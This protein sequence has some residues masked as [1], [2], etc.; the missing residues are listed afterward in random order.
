ML[1]TAVGASIPV[2]PFIFSSGVQALVISFVISTLA[3]F[4]VGAS[5]VIVTG[6]SWLKSGAEMTLI[7]IGEAAITYAIGM[8]IAPAFG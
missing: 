7:G 8:L 2:I 5:K 1:S 3:H 6:R 4:A